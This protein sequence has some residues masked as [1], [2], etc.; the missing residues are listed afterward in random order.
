[1]SIFNLLSKP[2]VLIFNLLII[3][4]HMQFPVRPPDKSAYW[5]MN[6]LIYI[7]GAHKDSLDEINTNICLN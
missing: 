4:L 1:M 5:K 6:F 2:R 7:V 3:P